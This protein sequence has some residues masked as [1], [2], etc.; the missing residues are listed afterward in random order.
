MRR[1]LLLA[2]LFTSTVALAADRQINQISVEQSDSDTIIRLFG[3][4]LI[5]SPNDR[6][7]F[8]AEASP[9]A[10]EPMMTYGDKE[11][12][13]VALGMAV[14]PGQYRISIGPNE[15]TSTLESMV[16]IGAIGPQGPQGRDGADG[17]DGVDG[18][19]GT[20]GSD[21]QDGAKGDPGSDGEDGLSCSVT[22]T[23]TGAT[24]ICTDGTMASITNGVNG[25]NGLNGSDGIDGS[26]CTV[27]EQ[28][29][30]AMIQCPDGTSATI[31]T[32]QNVEDLTSDLVSLRLAFAELTA[33]VEAVEGKPNSDAD[34]CF[35][36]AREFNPIFVKEF[37]NF[38]RSYLEVSNSG[39]LRLGDQFTLET[40]VNLRSYPPIFSTGSGSS[41][42]IQKRGVSGD[43]RSFALRVTDQGRVAYDTYSD[44]TLGSGESI[45]G[46]RIVRLNEWTHIAVTF[47]GGATK[48]FINGEL[49]AQGTLAQPFGGTKN[50]LLGGG[51][52]ASR[53]P[54]SVDG[55]MDNIRVSSK[56]RYENPF[57]PPS[58]KFSP[59]DET[60]LLFNF[61]NGLENLGSVGGNALSVN[62]NAVSCA[63]L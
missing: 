53:G 41:R 59:D 57:E 5:R 33:R 38:Q 51:D 54:V 19:D 63:N 7:F 25:L 23:A 22:Q 26:S 46:S 44:G 42:L 48:I 2:F 31:P 43:N 56:V 32:G 8:A 49:D 37:T 10:V 34:G 6:L 52:S 17:R 61:E 60:Q 24:V 45:T 14:M 18:R 30:G 15:N 28:E 12:V 20:D 27:D 36:S 11:Y 4:D 35:E 62:T 47:S 39:T 40:Y 58:M 3:S 1:S 9:F 55:Y 50:V 29:T 16:I 21:G 13:E